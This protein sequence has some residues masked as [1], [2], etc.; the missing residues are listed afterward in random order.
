MNYIRD[1]KTPVVL[2]GEQEEKGWIVGDTYL[3]VKELYEAGFKFHE[4][5]GKWQIVPGVS[6]MFKLSELQRQASN[7][8]MNPCFKL[9]VDKKKKF[10]HLA[11]NTFPHRDRI[12]NIGGRYDGKTRTWRLKIDEWADELIEKLHKKCEEEQFRYERNFYRGYKKRQDYK[13]F[14]ADNEKE[15]TRV[16]EL[17]FSED[18]DR[19]WPMTVVD[20]KCY[21][22]GYHIIWHYYVQF[23]KNDERIKTEGRGL[24][25]P[26]CNC[27]FTN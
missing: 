22:C 7:K 11:G 15:L 20:P 19:W 2:C 4:D 27:D 26:G 8:P 24:T 25:C 18:G 5:T 17:A 14:L 1:N 13:K 21:R 3:F 10:Y 16:T 9:Y 23:E 6:E 12:K